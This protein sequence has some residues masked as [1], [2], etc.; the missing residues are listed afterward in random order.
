[1]AFGLTRFASPLPAGVAGFL[2]SAR[3]L[4]TS[5]RGSLKLL[6]VY[7]SANTLDGATTV[8]VFVDGSRDT[9]LKITIPAGNIGLFTNTLNEVG[10]GPEIRWNFRIITLGT[11]GAITIDSMSVLYADPWT[12]AHR[13]DLV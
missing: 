2:V 11:A 13:T 10:V 9:L 4:S 6:S 7:V 12:E 8:D 1:M 5:A 3:D